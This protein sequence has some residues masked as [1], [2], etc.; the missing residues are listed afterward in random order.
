MAGILYYHDSI[1]YP[2]DVYLEIY[3]PGIRD[4]GNFGGCYFKN[5]IL[6][7]MAKEQSGNSMDDR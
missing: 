3:L 6:D 4:T 1:L 7:S 2:F 5:V